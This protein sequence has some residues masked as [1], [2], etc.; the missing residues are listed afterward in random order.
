MNSWLNDLPSA[1]KAGES[2]VLE[3]HPDDARDLGLV[4]GDL[5]AVESSVGRIEL[6][7]LVSDRP[8]RGVVITEHGWGSNGSDAQGANRNVLT[9]D[10]DIDELSA[11]PA[12]STTRVRVE[13]VG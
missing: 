5:A 13:R 6:D 9:A 12:F 3:M 4:T 10:T 7:V 11:T 1:R 2:N 8:Q